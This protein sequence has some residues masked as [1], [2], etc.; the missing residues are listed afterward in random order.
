[1]LFF[2]YGALECADDS[3]GFNEFNGCFI[4]FVEIYRFIEFQLI[5]L[6]YIRTSEYSTMLIFEHRKINVEDYKI[7]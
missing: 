5:H 7:F 4:Y 6:V 3:H 1:V 2:G